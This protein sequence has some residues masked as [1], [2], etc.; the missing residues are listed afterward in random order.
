MTQKSSWYSKIPHPLIM[1]FGIIVF[2][3]VLTHLLPAG[4]YE[5][6]NVGG[7]D[8]VVPGS[9]QIVDAQPVS[10]FNMFRAFPEGYLKATP[11][12]FIC[13]ASALMFA[14]LERTKTIENAVGTLLRKVG[15]GGGE[16]V[17]VALT[18]IYGFLGI[19]VGYENNMA[20]VPIAAVVILALGGDLVLAAGVSVGGMTVAFGLS[21]VNHYTVG[22]G[23]QIAELPYF[24]GW[25]LRSIICA[26]GLALMAFYNLRYYRRIRS[27]PELSI[28]QDLDTQGL[29]LS[30]PL[31]EF[32]IS[33]RNT[34]LLLIFLAGIIWMLYGIF[35]Y[36]WSI[37]DVSAVFL[38][39]TVSLAIFSGL[40]G[41]E[42]SEAGM[43]AIAQMAPATFIIGMAAV[44]KVVGPSSRRLCKMAGRRSFSWSS[45]LSRSERMAKRARTSSFSLRWLRTSGASF[46][47]FSSR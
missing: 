43:A 21:P 20:T 31:N 17:V 41:R 22:I 26:G 3:T 47:S 14:L 37:N 40:K 5:R 23:H 4:M 10:F 34:L 39:M 28:G 2:A 8:R 15:Q 18:I 45:S 11:I 19:L 16:I 33:R 9:F 38:I 44:V 7:R 13:L 36:Q 6:V 1:L 25:Q 24:S 27:Q 32:S 12:I 46:S 42:I 35:T 30:K 29:S